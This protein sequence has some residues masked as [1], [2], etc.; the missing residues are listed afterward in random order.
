LAL[1]RVAGAMDRGSA[2]FA[3]WESLKGFRQLHEELGAYM[4]ELAIEQA[5]RGPNATTVSP[6]LGEFHKYGH[7]TIIRHLE[8]KYSEDIVKPW[9]DWIRHNP[10]WFE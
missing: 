1:V 4:D 8:S 9:S 10:W 3:Q 2:E 5:I 6:M 7:S